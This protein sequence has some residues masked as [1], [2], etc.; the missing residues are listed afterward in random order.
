MTVSKI[1]KTHDMLVN[2]E[3]SCV[4]LTQRYI[5]AIKAT[6]ARGILKYQKYPKIT[7]AI[8][9][10]NATTLFILEN[11]LCLSNFLAI[12]AK[13]FYFIILDKL[14]NQCSHS[15]QCSHCHRVTH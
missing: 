4:E 8:A 9:I 1:K 5:D 6:T 10:I 2:G 13:K 15:E 14:I 12:V 11:I 3:I 7:E